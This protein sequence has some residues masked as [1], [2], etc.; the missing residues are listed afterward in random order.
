MLGG[1]NIPQA[2][3]LVFATITYFNNVVPPFGFNWR[4]VG[5]K[6]KELIRPI[7]G[8]YSVDYD[9][10]LSLYE[11]L[12][13]ILTDSKGEVEFTDLAFSTYGKSGAFKITFVCEGQSVESTLVEVLSTVNSVSFASQPPAIITNAEVSLESALVPILEITN[14]YG[15]G[16]AGKTPEIKIVHSPFTTYP[17][18]NPFS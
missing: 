10:P 3:K 12:I 4:D 8:L 13:P 17:Y 1:S 9:N 15:Q 6:N 16:I 2:N 7:P 14:S 11:P 5:Y 18:T